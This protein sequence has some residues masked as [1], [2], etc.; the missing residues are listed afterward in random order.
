VGSIR[1]APEWA[2][3]DAVILVWPH[4]SSDWGEQLVSI[5]NTYIEMSRYI[6]RHQK[7]LLIAHNQTHIQHIQETLTQNDVPQDQILYLDI[8]TNDTWVRD[9][10]PIFT[11]TDNTKTLLNFKFDA[12][13]NKYEHTKDNQFNQAFKQK[14]NITA[15]Y[16]DI[17]FVFEAG[18]LEA[19]SQG[20]LLISSTCF[21]RNLSDKH[22]DL[23]TISKKL[24]QWFA[25]NNILWINDIVL[26][27][28]DTDGHIDTLARYCSDNVI[29]YTATSNHSDPNL[30]ALESLKAQLNNYKQQ[31][32]TDIELIPL[33]TP[34]SI[35]IHC[36]T[37][38]IPEGYLQ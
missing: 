20:D 11:N 3:Q 9:Y 28:D 16:E 22:L 29:T 32:S 26:Q 24:N 38:Q 35:V 12:W 33:P 27:G 34:K 7:L 17:N 8:P 18:N 4:P 5:E 2:R 36:A 37:M 10:G 30:A 15:E 21:K 25:C 23:N 1:L 31:S 19:N 13:G 14:L 6:A